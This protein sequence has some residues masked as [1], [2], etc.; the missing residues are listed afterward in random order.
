MRAQI[1]FFD[2]ETVRTG[3]TP[4]PSGIRRFGWPTDGEI[5]WMVSFICRTIGKMH[6]IGACGS[7]ALGEGRN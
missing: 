6:C 1:K 7:V 2:S 4:Q 3:E 5:A